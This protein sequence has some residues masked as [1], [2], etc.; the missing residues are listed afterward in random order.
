MA[1]ADYATKRLP[2][3]CGRKWRVASSAEES[4][5]ETMYSTSGVVAR[6]YKHWRRRLQFQY[7]MLQIHTVTL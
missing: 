6:T 3:K 2:V 5:L 1:S 4:R 7:E